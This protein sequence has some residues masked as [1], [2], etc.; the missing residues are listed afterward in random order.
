MAV[1][2]V[3]AVLA[4]I[5]PLLS[6]DAF[7][8][9]AGIVSLV[10]ALAATGWNLLGGY[11]GQV[12]FGHAAFFGIGAYATALLVRAGWSPWPT[13]LVGVAVAAAASA[14][15]GF[16]TFRLRG[17]YFSIAT[18]AV[19]GIT[20]TV[21]SNIQ[22]LGATGGL[23][24]P[25]KEPSLMNLQFSVLDKASYY[26]VALGMLALGLAVSAAFVR[27]KAG[28]Y[29]RAIRDD[30]EAAV[31]VGVPERHYKLTTFALSA[32]IT[33]AAG[34]FYA[35][36]VLFVDPPSTLDLSVSILIV[37]IAVL[38]G[39]GSLMGPIVGAWVVTFLKAYTV[40][41]LSGTGNGVDLMVYGALIM[42]IAVFEPGGI[43]GLTRRL[44]RPI[45]RISS[46]GRMGRRNADA[47]GDAA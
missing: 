15:I 29:I 3:A 47:G 41:H 42:V 35:M 20:L 4:V 32:A 6:R 28:Y 34:S 11:A 16:P 8:Q 22:S 10:F 31:A 45:S 18:I 1:W 23:E 46:S 17:H 12:S 9:D 36:Y 33:A 26:Y 7:W 44:V 30:H 43:V 13:M 14:V 40:A 38:G 25:L 2:S 5:Y 21:V 37:L 39:A 19:G 24:I 27:G